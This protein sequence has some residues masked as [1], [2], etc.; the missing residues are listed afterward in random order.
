MPLDLR[1]QCV[2]H[3]HQLWGMPINREPWYRIEIRTEIEHHGFAYILEYDDSCGIHIR[4]LVL[5][6][7]NV[8][9]R[10]FASHAVRNEC[11]NGVIKQCFE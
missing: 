4:G 2:D 8:S 1:E 3:C 7:L 11:C 9:S 5:D 10:E 6:S